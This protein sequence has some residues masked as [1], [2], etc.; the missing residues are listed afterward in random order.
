MRYIIFYI[1]IYIFLDL[2]MQQMNKNS[3][4]TGWNRKP[5]F[6]LNFFSDNRNNKKLLSTTRNRKKRHDKFLILAKSKLDSIETLISQAL[7][8]IE[9][10]HE[11]F[12]VIIREKQK[13]ERMKENLRNASEKQ[14]NMRLNSVNTR[15][16]TSL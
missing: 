14:K 5:K 10:S 13:Y 15:K 1:F 3:W 16:I 9:I 2:V 12:D 8:D 4:S 6:Y 7:I 11:E